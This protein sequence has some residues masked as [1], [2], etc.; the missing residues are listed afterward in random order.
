MEVLHCVSLYFNV[1]RLFIFILLPI[2]LN[3]R[4]SPSLLFLF[5]RFD[6]FRARFRLHRSGISTSGLFLISA[7]NSGIR[8]EIGFPLWGA[9]F[10]LIPNPL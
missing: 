8:S 5:L 4:R 10:Y 9:A 2:E 7:S 6:S 3:S 1:I